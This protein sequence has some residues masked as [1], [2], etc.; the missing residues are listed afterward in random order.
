M[1]IV[2]GV[3]EVDPSGLDK[4]LAA[5]TAMARDTNKEPGCR[6]YEFSQ[7]IG[8]PNCFRIYE[9]WDD[10]AALTAHFSAPHMATFR[11]ALAGVGIVSR[12]VFKLEDGQK[13]ALD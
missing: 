4:A 1:L 6:V 9:E 12:D 8:A 5:A 2:T 11:T 13:T 3:I 10:A 7:I